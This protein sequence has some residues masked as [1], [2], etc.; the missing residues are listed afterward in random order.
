[1]LALC[2]QLCILPWNAL[3][4]REWD[5]KDDPQLPTMHPADLARYLG[6]YAERV[7]TSILPG[8]RRRR[9]VAPERVV[10]GAGRALRW[11][12]TTAPVPLPRAA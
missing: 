12:A 3:D 9:R 10:R 5:R 11:C 2:V 8:D 7:M 6:L 4:A 1:M